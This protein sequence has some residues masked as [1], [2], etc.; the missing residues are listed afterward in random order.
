[1]IYRMKEEKVDISNNVIGD[2]GFLSHKN[3]EILI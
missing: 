1:M 2:N 3:V